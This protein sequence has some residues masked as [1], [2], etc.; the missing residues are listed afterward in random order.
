MHIATPYGFERRDDNLITDINVPF[1]TCALG[2][3]VT[4]IT[5]SGD[6]KTLRLPAGTQGGQ[7]LRISGHGMTKGASNPRGDMLVRIKIEVPKNLTARQRAAIDELAVALG[8]D[9]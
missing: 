7:Q 1:T 2:G 3:E 4:A 5:P 8:D 6:R 9:K